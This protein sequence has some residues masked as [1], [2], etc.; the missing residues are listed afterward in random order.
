MALSPICLVRNGSNPFQ[1]TLNGVN[2]TPGNTISIR[3]SDVTGVTDWYLEVIGSDELSSFPTLTNVNP[4]TNRV[5][6]P[7]FTVT[8]PMAAYTGRALLF[9]STVEGPT[10]SMYTT[11]TV[12]TVTNL[13]R[14]VA[15]AGETTEGNASYGWAAIVNPIIRESY[16]GNV[17]EYDALPGVLLNDAVYSAGDGLVGRADASQPETAPAIGMVV[18]IVHENRVL[19]LHQGNFTS[20]DPLTVGPY[21]LGITPGTLTPYAPTGS[22]QVV[23]LVGRAVSAD[24]LVLASS[25]IT[26]ELA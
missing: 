18:S 4:V 26:V 15:A 2:V 23:Q 13:G 3:L 1:P 25:Y 24:T 11:F 5:L 20:P 14:R 6:D 16:N 17:R 10:G 21:F 9:K 22:G 12:Y 19:V 7:T 8:F